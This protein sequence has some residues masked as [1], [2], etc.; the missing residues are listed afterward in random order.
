MSKRVVI[1]LS[2]SLAVAVVFLLGASKAHI[3]EDASAAMLPSDPTWHEE[4]QRYIDEFPGD[5]SVLL[6]TDGLLCTAQ[7][8]ELLKAIHDDLENLAHTRMVISIAGE[9]T[10]Y[11]R[12]TGDEISVDS[13]AHLTFDKATDRCEAAASYKP[14][15]RALVSERGTKSVF[16]VFSKPKQDA[17]SITTDMHNLV[18]RYQPAIDA[19]GGTIELTGEPILSAEVS[20]L[21]ANDSR[22]IALTFMMMLALLALF[23][24]SIHAVVATLALTTFVLSVAYGT[25]GWL[26]ISI[27]PATTLTVFLLV[28][29]TSAFVIH[30]FAYDVRK[31]M[32]GTRINANMAFVF[33]GISTCIG[34]AATGMTP[35]QD[36]QNMAL[37]GVVG[38]IAAASGV[39][40]I[41][42]PILGMGK[43]PRPLIGS[44]HAIKILANPLL[45]ITLLVALSSL[46]VYGLAKIEFNYSPTTSSL[47]SD[48]PA[49]VSYEKIRHDFGGMGVPVLF[50]IDPDQQ[51][52]T[53]LSINNLVQEIQAEHNGELVAHWLFP[54]LN[55]LSE[56]FSLDEH[57]NFNSFPKSDEALEQFLLL[58]DPQQLEPYLSEDRDIAQLM[59][60]IP[61]SGS[62]DY[63]ELRNSIEVA[64]SRN[65][66]DHTITG[67]VPAFFESG[68]RIGV[69]TIQGLFVGACM[70][71]MLLCILFKSFQLALAGIIVNI[72]PVTVGLATLGLFQVSIDMGSSIVAAI[73][74]GILLDDSMHLLVRVRDYV[75]QGYDPST[76]VFQALNELIGPITATT[77]TIALGFS[78]LFLADLPS[79]S[80]F[81]LVML[82]TLFS[83]LVTDIVALPLFVKWLYR[84]PIR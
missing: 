28:P 38:I 72:I 10:K 82:V 65:E 14:F 62:R 74:F 60:Q 53:W 84:D 8:W 11:A 18:K 20:V 50:R 22:Y 46:S 71:F 42:F 36:I 12:A 58:F 31:R 79:F 75:T 34:F 33:A 57:G 3:T 43:S 7:G 83:A 73:A 21:V 17:V 52:Q 48:N 80:N 81:A 76:A 64:A 67:R 59:L 40:V 51:V 9:A 25:M 16:V 13:F 69:D 5:N 27:T 77:F 41:V 68:H 26:E 78:I 23:T 61:Y 2:A 37:M 66:L 47:G 55:E 39:F 45:G 15:V 19:L 56:K 6:A 70:L 1:R 24:R 54:H 4:Y 49:R 29:L 30:A 35:A 63:I 44:R 32:S